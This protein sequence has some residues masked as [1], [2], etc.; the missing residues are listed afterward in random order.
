MKG[1][2]KPTRRQKKKQFVIVEEKKAELR[3]KLA[4][5]DGAGGDERAVPD[6]VPRALHRLYQ[7]H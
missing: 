6:G 2:N 7:K 3:Q 5:G 4:A 1:K